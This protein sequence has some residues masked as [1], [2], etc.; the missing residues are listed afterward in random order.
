MTSHVKYDLLYDSVLVQLQSPV[1][2]QRS[3]PPILRSLFKT[4]YTINLNYHTVLHAF[5]AL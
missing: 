5:G 4:T 2:D 1:V 3:I